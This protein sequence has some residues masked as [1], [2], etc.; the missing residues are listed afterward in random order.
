MFERNLDRIIKILSE[1]PQ[2]KKNKM[3]DIQKEMWREESLMR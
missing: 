2:K 1:V 3:R